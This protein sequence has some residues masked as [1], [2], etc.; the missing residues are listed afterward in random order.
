MKGATIIQLLLVPPYF[1]HTLL[2]AESYIF[3]QETA[4]VI[5]GYGDQIISI[6]QP[7]LSEPQVPPKEK[8]FRGYFKI[9][10]SVPT[11]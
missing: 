7:D 10:R 6:Q 11:Y 5:R 3:L 2:V 9:A 8:K 4:E 1:C